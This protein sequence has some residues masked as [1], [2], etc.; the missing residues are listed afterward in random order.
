[1]LGK[2]TFC[3]RCVKYVSGGAISWFSRAQKVPASTSSEWEYEALAE[4]VNEAKLLSQM[5]KF[6]M[7]NLRSYTFQ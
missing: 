4:I 1:M 6:T 2:P 3:L 7:N 5:Q